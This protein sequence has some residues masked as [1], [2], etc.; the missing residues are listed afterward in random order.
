MSIESLKARLPEYARDLR[1]NLGS[2]ATESALTE[3]QRAGTFLACAV[4]CREPSVIEA[5]LSAFGPALNAEQI[6]GAKT[7][8]ALMAMNNIYYRFTHLTSN[9]D[10]GKMR[11]NLR[12]SALHAPGV[13]KVEMELWCLAASAINGCGVCVDSHEKT[14]RENG[15]SADQIQAAARIAA[16]VHA[17][18]VVLDAE[19]ALKTP[20]TAAA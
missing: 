16:V 12:M 4:A 10:Y 14:L 20:V 17:V 9:P 18:S 5:V 8:A 15:L 6:N 2:L 13:A 7:A 19:N 3:T 11:A 1:L